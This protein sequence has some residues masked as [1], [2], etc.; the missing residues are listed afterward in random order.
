MTSA[1]LLP[2]PSPRSS[3][4]ARHHHHHS[5]SPLYSSSS[6]TTTTTAEGDL[7]TTLQQDG[8]FTRFLSLLQSTGLASTLTNTNTN[9]DT[10]TLLA[11]TD[12]ALDDKG[13]NIT[14][15]FAASKE[16]TNKKYLSRIL[17]YHIIPGE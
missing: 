15:A 5:F 2:T 4:L 16:D 9:T 17:S 3:P 1:F 11:P 14:L 12:A 10:Y 6:S 7:L 13:T 8:R